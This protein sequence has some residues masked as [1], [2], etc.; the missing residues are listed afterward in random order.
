MSLVRIDEQQGGVKKRTGSKS[1]SN[2]LNLTLKVIWEC[3]LP[4]LPGHSPKCSPN[5]PKIMKTDVNFHIL[6]LKRQI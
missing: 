2:G 1:L 6:E 3:G 4:Y 5:T